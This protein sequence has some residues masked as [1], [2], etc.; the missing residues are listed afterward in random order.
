MSAEFHTGVDLSD[1][2]RFRHGPEQEAVIANRLHL[3][4][5]RAIRDAGVALARSGQDFQDGKVQV[6]LVVNGRS[7]VVE[8]DVKEA[9]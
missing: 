2:R 6:A 4:L 3:A 1:V 7:F 9:A 8:P 5:N